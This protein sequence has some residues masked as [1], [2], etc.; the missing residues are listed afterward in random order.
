MTPTGSCFSTLGPQLVMLL[1]KLWNLYD[2]GTWGALRFYS[3]SLVSIMHHYHHFLPVGQSVIDQPA[4][5]SCHML[6]Q[7]V[8]MPTLP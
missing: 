7:T 2:M 1:G 3:L 6:S 8:A 4:S 5:C